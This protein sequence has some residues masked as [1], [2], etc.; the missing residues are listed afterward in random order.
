VR[1]TRD[2]QEEIL[3]RA[4]DRRLTRRLWETARPHRRLV[5]GATALFPVIALF[6]LAQPYLL[7]VAI[8]EH[9]LTADWLGLSLVALLYAGT[10]AVLY[11]LRMLE[12]YLMAVTGQRVIHDLRRT[13]VGHLLRLEAAFF[14]ANPVG[15]LMTRVLNDVEAVSEAFTSGLFAVV[16]DL[17][18]I[19]GVVAVMLWMDWRL[20]LVTYSIVPV[21]L[22]V[23]SYF[24]LRA[25]DAYRQVRTR[26]ARLNA[27]LQ[28][29][30]QGMSVIQLFARERHEHARFRALNADYR[31]ALFGSTIFEAS[32]YASVEALGSVAL[33]LLVWY[34]GGRI[35]DGHLTFGALVAFIQYTSRF[36]LPIRDLGAKY[37]VMQSAMASSERIF[38]LLDRAPAIVSPPA[39]GAPGRPRA[40]AAVQF[41]AVWFAYQDEQWVLRDC[42]L[43]IAPGE[44]VALVGA[45][46]EGKSTIARLLNRSYDVRSGQVLV[47][48]VDV[49]EWDLERLRRHVGIIFQDTVLFAGTVEANLVLDGRNGGAPARAELERLVDAANALGVVRALPGGFDATLSER[50]SNLSHGQRQ[51]LAIARALVYNPRV[52]VLDEATSSVDPESEWMIREGMKRLSSGRTT[53]TIA[54]RLSTIQSADRIL[55]LHRGRVHEQGT[56]GELLRRGGLY[57]R[58]H[59]LQTGGA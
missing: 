45:T 48:G 37:T 11:G 54:H 25:R 28:E 59:E 33:A 16:A 26:L 12:A 51:L 15:R 50:G 1:E 18:T 56:H 7:K 29:S 3:G 2:E 42:A 31:R 4:F 10:L 27:F 57:A 49:R 32:L 24:R 55:V 22:G 43:E 13:L 20:A 40:G 47:D 38:D 52:L 6:E 58:L 44:H 35:V 53:L 19:A 46:G 5:L 34:G 23:A 41:R 36:F 39:P 30:L 17:V 9:I 8:D 21:L 14:D